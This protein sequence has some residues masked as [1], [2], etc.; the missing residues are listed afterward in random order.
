M[1]RD[2]LLAGQWLGTS[3]LEPPDLLSWGL[4]H[5]PQAASGRAEHGADLRK[6]KLSLSL[7]Q[8][9]HH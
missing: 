4:G 1:G 6:Q 8:K 3:G 7:L 2:Q 9:C 5:S